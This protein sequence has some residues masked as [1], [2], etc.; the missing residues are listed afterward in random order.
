MLRLAWSWCTSFFGNFGWVV[1][2]ITALI[3]F[4]KWMSIDLMVVKDLLLI[5]AIIILAGK[6]G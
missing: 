3:A 2:A 5:T 4:F 6:K 1:A